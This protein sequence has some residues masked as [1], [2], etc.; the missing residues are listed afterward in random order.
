MAVFALQFEKFVELKHSQLRLVQK[1][2][3]ICKKV[4]NAEFFE[5]WR[6]PFPMIWTWTSSLVGTR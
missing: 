2:V 3:E 1:K 6:F 5:I 4:Q